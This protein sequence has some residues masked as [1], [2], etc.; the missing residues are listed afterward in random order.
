MRILFLAD[1][2]S[3]HTKKWAFSLSER[4]VE[5]GVFTLSVNKH[6]E[7]YISRNIKV[8][9]SLDLGDDSFHSG[10]LSK[11]RYIKA[12]RMLKSSIAEFKPYIVHAHYASSYGLLGA[13]S[14]FHPFIISVWGTDVYEFPDAGLLQKNILRYNLS[15]A[16]VILS[17]SHVMK[18]RIKEF[19]SK[20]I[21]VTPFG[22]DPVEFDPTMK[23]LD[24]YKDRFV[25]GIIKSM[26]EKYGI[27]YLIRAFH[28]IL[29][30]FPDSPL[31]LLLVGSGSKTEEYRSLVDELKITDKVTFTGRIMH[32]MI[33][34]YHQTLN[35]SVNPSTL[36]SES[37]GV[38]VVEAMAMKKPVI[39]SEIGGLKEVVKDNVT[40]LYV[41]PM[42][43]D[44]IVSA[45]QRLINDPELRIELGEKARKHVVRE[46]DWNQ[47]IGKVIDEVYIPLC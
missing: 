44:S 37:F 26:E 8:F 21:R 12:V 34:A 39:V 36:E 18:E 15:K 17:T 4:G 7:E 46:Y 28:T 11:I 41:K 14:G 9:S 19:T 30:E 6:P 31:H 13:L 29:N 20:P 16:D 3:S 43:T 24:E 42:D 25:I 22:I 23:G 5:V 27:K 35:I 10:I 47:I 1:C 40:G 45:L 38:S 32:D 2:N 33:P